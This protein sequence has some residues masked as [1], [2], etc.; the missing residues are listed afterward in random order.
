MVGA[1]VRV[2]VREEGRL[3]FSVYVKV[4]AE[5]RVG[6]SVRVELRVNAFVFCSFTDP[7]SWSVLLFV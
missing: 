7:G 5:G 1:S 2:E 4:R 3:S 6:V